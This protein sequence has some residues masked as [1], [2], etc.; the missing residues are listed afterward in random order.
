MVYEHWRELNASGEEGDTWE[1]SKILE[2]IRDYNIDDCES[3][4]EL[5]DW[6]R[7]QQASHG[8]AFAGRTELKEGESP[9]AVTER[10]Q[11]RDR[12]L[13]RAESERESDPNAAAL[14]ENLAWMLDFHRREDKP[15]YWRRFDRLDTDASEL[16]D[17]LDC[18]ALCERTAREPIPPARK[19][20]NSGHEYKY[21][22]EQGFK[23]TAKSYFVHGGLMPDESLQRANPVAADS[24]PREG[25]IVFRS[26][27]TLPGVLTVIPDEIVPAEN[28][29]SAISDVVGRYEDGSLLSNGSAIVDFLRRVKPKIKIK[30]H[31]DGPIAPSS[32]PSSRLEE[33]IKAVK[34]LDA[35]YLPI[36]GPPG[37][38]KTYTGKMVIAELMKSGARVGIASNS[39]KAINNLL[40]ATAKQCKAERIS[41]S[42][43]CTSDT[44]PA[45]ADYGVEICSN[46][47]LGTK[48][49]PSS[50]IG[51]T[52][53]GFSRPELIDKFD[54]LF[55]DEAGQVST[56]NLV[57]MSRS[58]KNL[59]LLGDQ[60]QLGQPTQGTHPKESGLSVLDYL[61]HDSPTIAPEMGVFLGTT[62]RMHS[63]VNEF[64][65]EHVYDG[66][67]NAYPDNDKRVIA[68]PKAYLGPLNKEAGIVF[69][70]VAHSGN[71]QASDE[72][73]E[74]IHQ[75]AKDLIGRTFHTGEKKPATRKIGW[76]DILFVAPYN[77]QV[78]KLR[79]RLGQ[80]ARIGSV[81][82]F[83]GQE[84]P[85][86][87]LSMCAS[88]PS[89]SPRGMDF[90][91]DKNRL[92]V[93]LSRAQ[94]LAI[95]VAN[96][97]IADVPV[98][99]VAHLRLLNLF[100]GIVRA[101]SG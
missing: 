74:T 17:D 34:Q 61:L 70:P 84:A 3:T 64:I 53:W 10:T 68:V 99:K 56:A 97:G 92:N 100:C 12:L 72:E 19:N 52:A 35:S 20:G 81:D 4:Q 9:E 69:V 78:N 82:K 39:H 76:D 95:V 21:D 90:L 45:L 60:M 96:P 32:D 93:A 33:V 2:A 77:H 47:K 101:G 79:Q 25:L 58:A 48:V 46:P 44:D 31:K 83:Q 62:F 71:T 67:L 88:D 8:I 42:F 22:L 37:S 98:D 65:S 80:D 51:S 85:V 6:L 36:Q 50:V 27:Q 18:L 91:F 38:G 66:K 63:A 43:I 57:A 14:T 55:V 11:L 89:E 94:S 73:V 23:A 26:S 16:V 29:V 54:Y 75:L 30:G 86:V 41:A 87:I 15:V 24:D 7:E 40:L 13:A 49:Q 59:I 1:T 28:I 5:V